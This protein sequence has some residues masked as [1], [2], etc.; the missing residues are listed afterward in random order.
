[1]E[2]LLKASAVIIIF[3]TCYKLLLQR[4][5]FFETN[6]WFLLIGLIFAVL[7]PFVVI[8]IYIEYVPVVQNFIITNDTITSQDSAQTSFNALNIVY[9]VYGIG[10]LFFL[11]K[12]GLEFSSL[13]SL[14]KNN[15]PYKKGAYT[16]IETNTNILP[17]SFFKHI[18]YNKQQFDET[19]LD[20][21][22]N[23]EKVHASQFHSIDI[24]LI[25]LA[26]TVFWFNPFIWLYKKEIQQN[27]EFI[28]D[29]KAQTISN[30]EKSYQT[31][32]LKASLPNYQFVL[33]NNFYNSLIKKRIVM[34][35]KSKSNKLNVWKYALV[36]PI[37][38]IFLMNANTKEI[39]IEKSANADASIANADPSV[40]K[41]VNNILNSA[42]KKEQVSDSSNNLK[43]TNINNKQSNKSFLTSNQDPK[44]PKASDEHEVVIISKDITDSELES[45][46]KQMDSKG[47]TVKFKGVKRNSNNE[48][49]AIKI[50]VS[51]KKSNANYHTESDD[52]IK[53]ISINVE[54][55]KISIGNSGI[56]HSGDHAFDFITKD[57]KHKVHST[58]SGDNVFFFTGDEDDEKVVIR[59]VDK[60][61]LAP[62]STGKAHFI[63]EDGNVSAIEAESIVIKEN[64]NGKIDT[65]H[66]KKMNKGNL[67]WVGKEHEGNLFKVKENT[68]IA[69]VGDTDTL[70]VKKLNKGKAIW[71]DKEDDSDIIAIENGN[72][73]KFF[74]SSDG[75][76]P[77][78][79]L[80]GKEI[81][82]EEMD[83]IKP[84]S[85]EK[86]E[87]LKGESAT[88]KY[89]DN[90][91]NGVILITTK[92]KK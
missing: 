77:L 92:D 21:I 74:F 19:E 84:D 11:V 66:V 85:I 30:C 22:I 45:L 10:V 75:K 40:E 33:A 44:A 64:K 57:G 8:P 49:T 6:R 43:P 67:V 7:I 24:I 52:P 54:N 36:L 27:L 69:G 61:H 20:H 73:N 23:H 46:K 42:E 70:I 4:E 82:R 62:K 80:N 15:K 14:L 86:V 88:K 53:P 48:I 28:A 26:S 91:Q 9:S 71:V 60:I 37:L 63:S 51:S 78:Y 76:E 31:L 1:M 90:G 47:I 56:V 83:A 68:I 39:Y 18:V 81:S 17:F 41:V 55:D 25:Q 38:A 87:V 13:I 89:G 29:K 79:I 2:Y 59:N 32:L 58:G 72:N 12:L 65:I 50:D 16:F 34:L 5:T 35:H 3:Y